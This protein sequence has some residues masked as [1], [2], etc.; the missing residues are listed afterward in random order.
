MYFQYFSNIE[1]RFI[2]TATF[3]ESEY[4]M[5]FMTKEKGVQ[6]KFC[7]KN[8]IYDIENIKAVFEFSNSK[9]LQ[10]LVIAERFNGNYLNIINK[11]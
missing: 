4:D 5:F 3:T 9:Y 6:L 10:F 2:P 1:G 8:D 7:P 11:L